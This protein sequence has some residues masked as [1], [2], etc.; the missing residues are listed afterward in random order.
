[1]SDLEIYQK[2][3]KRKEEELKEN[4]REG[5]EIKNEIAELKQSIDRLEKG[6][7]SVLPIGTK[8]IFKDEEGQEIKTVIIEDY[9]EKQTLILLTDYWSSE[10]LHKWYK[11]NYN[12]IY[13]D[14]LINEFCNDFNV[15]VVKIDKNNC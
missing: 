6:L 12:C 15:E 10:E 1:M 3:L 13:S 5:I 11:F 7:Q 8:I 4:I 2:S 9:K 14:T